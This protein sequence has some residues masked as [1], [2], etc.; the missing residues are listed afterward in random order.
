MTRASQQQREAD[1]WTRRPDM[2]AYLCSLFIRRAGGFC[3]IFDKVVV[4]NV[5]LFVVLV[6]H[7]TAHNIY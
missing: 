6:A 7:R 4:N 2:L 5:A 1:L 3:G